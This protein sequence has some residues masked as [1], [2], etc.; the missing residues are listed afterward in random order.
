MHDAFIEGAN[1]LV[2][3]PLTA[4]IGREDLRKGE[5]LKRMVRT[6]TVIE[7]KRPYNRSPCLIQSLSRLI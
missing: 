2:M 4:L 5:G 6:T 3:Y 7:L 1:E